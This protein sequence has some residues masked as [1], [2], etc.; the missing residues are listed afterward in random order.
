[1]KATRFHTLLLCAALIIICYA[2]TLRGM[3]D[4][5]W[6][7]EDMGHGFVVPIV[8]L[9]IG[10]A[11][12]GRHTAVNG[13]AWRWSFRKLGG[14]FDHNRGNGALLRRHPATSRLDI[15]ISGG[16]VHAAETGRRV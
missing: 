14:V 15:S 3:F 7:D 10:G 11:G 16:A 2:P 13:R 9:G 8:I 4:Q 1:M 5:W 6:T 12:S